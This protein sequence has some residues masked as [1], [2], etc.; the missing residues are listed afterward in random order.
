M[1]KHSAAVH[2]TENRQYK[3]LGNMDLLKSFN[4]DE[5]PEQQTRTIHLMEKYPDFDLSLGFDACCACGKKFGPDCPAINCKNCRRV[6]YCSDACRHSDAN[7]TLPD[8]SNT[9]EGGETALGHTAVVCALLKTCEEDEDV[10]YNEFGNLDS[11]KIQSAK[12]RIQSEKES[13]PA[14]LA[15]VIAE[16][17]CYTETL[18][19][20]SASRKLVVHVVGAS[21]EAELWNTNEEDRSFGNAYADALADLSAKWKLDIVELFFLG[22]EC[23]KE[24]LV[25]PLRMQN[26]EKDQPPSEL[27]IRTIK[28]EYTAEVLHQNAIPNADI[29]VF[30][31]PGF[32]VPDYQWN[33]TL[34]CI[35]KGT[36]FLSTTNT[37]MEGIADCQYLIDQDRIKSVPPG[38]AEI[39]G[40]YC[41]DDDD[42]DER[43][44]CQNQ[45]ISFFSDNPF[46]GSRVRQ[47]GTMANDLFL[48]NHWILG[49]I[50]D[51]FDPT[52]GRG[53]SP[54][55]K[56]KGIEASSN[57]KV[58]NPA[59]I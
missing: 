25:L 13:Y 2:I 44:G 54:S 15:N 3:A 46:C 40:V 53:N 48:K 51:S 24:K 11:A 34:A 18:Q 49:G 31:N 42:Q 19:K 6:S 23:P 4:L 10:E 57:K 22:P 41:G 52:K 55:K 30:F 33:E 39:F 27:I 50:I 58:G 26:T 45:E 29:V 36:P 9:E 21:V 56:L 16:G 20:C 32:T 35:E 17:P 43:D 59:L 37:E 38:L 12:D 28:G 1:T 14:T 7:A 8:P 5:L 47:N